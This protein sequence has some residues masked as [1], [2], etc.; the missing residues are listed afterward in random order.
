[1]TVIYVNIQRA[2]SR[3]SFGQQKALNEIYYTIN[4]TYLIANPL[5][6]LGQLLEKVL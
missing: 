6:L 3:Y 1:M 2:R 4:Y 5:R